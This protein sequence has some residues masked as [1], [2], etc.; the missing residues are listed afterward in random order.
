MYAVRYFMHEEVCKSC[1]QIYKADC[2]NW[3]NTVKDSKHLFDILLHVF[4]YHLS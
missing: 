4:I 1:L 2:I 3:N